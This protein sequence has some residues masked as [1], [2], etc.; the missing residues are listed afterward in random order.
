MHP[1][2]D[3]RLAE[4][5]EKIVESGNWHMNADGSECNVNIE[6]SDGECNCGLKDAVTAALR[7]WAKIAE[8]RGAIERQW[9]YEMLMENYA[10]G[11]R[12]GNAFKQATPQEIAEL[13]D[14][15]YPKKADEYAASLIPPAEGGNE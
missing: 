6:D 8:R 4:E 10:V 9:C 13:L 2:P 11:E 12:E 1:T 14:V 15:P 7:S 5:A 3:P